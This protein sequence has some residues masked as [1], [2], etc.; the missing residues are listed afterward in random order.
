[1]NPKKKGPPFELAV[2]IGA[3]V[4]LFLKWLVRL[5]IKYYHL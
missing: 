5:I 2:I 1:M 4:F 3:I